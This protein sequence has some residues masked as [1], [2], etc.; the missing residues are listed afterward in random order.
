MT[1]P[2]L[3]FEVDRLSCCIS[4]AT[5]KELKDAKRLVDRAKCAKQG[6]KGTWI[7]NVMSE[8]IV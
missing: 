6:G 8:N 1:R 4:T 3:S 7:K 2:D 5:F